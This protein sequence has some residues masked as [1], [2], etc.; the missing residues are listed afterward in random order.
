MGLQWRGTL[1]IQKFP[2]T[3][4]THQY[5]PSLRNQLESVLAEPQEELP[6]LSHLTAL[7]ERIREMFSSVPAVQ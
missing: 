3:H 1:A 5:G 2:S 4:T 7:E 6:V